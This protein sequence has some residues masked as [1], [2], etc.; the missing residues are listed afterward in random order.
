MSRF[1][2]D[3]VEIR[4][5]LL[6]ARTPEPKTWCRHLENHGFGDVDGSYGKLP[7]AP[8]TFARQ[9][10]PINARNE[11]PTGAERPTRVSNRL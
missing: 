2:A 4:G 10:A 3:C 9:T 1:R 8:E 7:L 5:L 6:L 11:H